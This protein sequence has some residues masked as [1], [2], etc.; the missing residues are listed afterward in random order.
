MTWQNILK[1]RTNESTP[2]RL[3]G[4]NTFLVNDDIYRQ[5]GGRVL[6]DTEGDRFMD[7][8]DIEEVIERKLTIKDFKNHHLNWKSNTNQTLLDR[9]GGMRGQQ[10]LA[11]TQIREMLDSLHRNKPYDSQEM[12]EMIFKMFLE[13]FGDTSNLTNEVVMALNMYMG[14]DATRG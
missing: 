2:E 10:K 7:I 12:Y 6:G 9:V 4:D 5:S 8:E 13:V 14:I 1:V 3:H 11:E